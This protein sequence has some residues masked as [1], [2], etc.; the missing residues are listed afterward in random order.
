[1][2]FSSAH[3][4]SFTEAHQMATKYGT[5]VSQNDIPKV[6]HWIHARKQKLLWCDGSVMPQADVKAY[7]AMPFPI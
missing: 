2:S 5:T 4:S 7:L 1:M 3:F 6:Y